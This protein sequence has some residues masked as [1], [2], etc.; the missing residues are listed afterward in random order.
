VGKKVI[1]EYDS[2]GSAIR[3]YESYDDPWG[4]PPTNSFFQ[5]LTLTKLANKFGTDKG[6]TTGCCSG[7]T[8]LYEHYF[9]YSRHDKINILEIG[10]NNGGPEH[11]ENNMNRKIE[12]FPSIR[13]WHEYYHKADIWGFDINALKTSDTDLER[14]R[15][16]QGDQ[17]SLDSY[18]DFKKVLKQV[19]N[20]TS[21]IFEIIIDDASHAF[22]HQQLSFI[23]L[24]SL[25]K[26]GGFY[27]IEDTHWQPNEDKTKPGQ[28]RAVFDFRLLPETVDTTTL[29]D[30]GGENRA[31]EGRP[32]V[33]NSTS[34]NERFKQLRPEIYNDFV[35]MRE[36]F[37]VLDRKPWLD[38]LWRYPIGQLPK[39]NLIL[40]RRKK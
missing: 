4:M 26:I 10:L 32:L 17:G 34:A 7:F 6:T 39:S 30:N 19:Y 21:E 28:G 40:L 25:V 15:F 33:P 29:F 3:T 20:K 27:I 22:Y 35:K 13:M 36:K 9:E 37:E 2:E 23:N 18:K 12:D 5:K 38:D 8:L 31:G 1:T 24:A 16:F 14:F 11:G